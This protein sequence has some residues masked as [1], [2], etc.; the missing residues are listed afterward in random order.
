MC[1][2]ILR[3]QLMSLT[4]LH[5]EPTYRPYCAFLSILTLPYLLIRLEA[6]GH[7]LQLMSYITLPVHVCLRTH[8][9][10]HPRRPLMFILLTAVVSLQVTDGTEQCVSETK[11]QCWDL[12]EVVLLLLKVLGIRHQLFARLIS[13]MFKRTDI[14]CCR[15]SLSCKT[16]DVVI[17]FHA[18]HL[19]TCIRLDCQLFWLHLLPWRMQHNHWYSCS[20][21]FEVSFTFC[22]DLH[23][24]APPADLLIS[25]LRAR[26]QLP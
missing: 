18:F 1:R 25:L 11:Y 23:F 4:S 9:K 2:T 16:E 20:S 8:L 14:L 6:V 13:D 19:C 26:F 5:N 15:F 10:C 12:F 22:S 7:T 21:A 3:V 24:A 17:H